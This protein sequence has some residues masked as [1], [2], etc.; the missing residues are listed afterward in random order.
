MSNVP[1]L[2]TAEREGEREGEGGREKEGDKEGEHITASSFFLGKF[3]ENQNTFCTSTSS[4]VVNQKSSFLLMM[5]IH[6]ILEVML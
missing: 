6:K 2:I 1:R 3:M 5:P 4:E